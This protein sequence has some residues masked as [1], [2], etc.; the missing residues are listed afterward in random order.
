MSF[1]SLD[2][3][4]F[5]A[6]VLAGLALM[7]TRHARHVFLLIASLVFYAFGTPWFVVVLL[8][9]SIVDYACAI[10]MEES[11]DPAVRR[12]WLVLSLVTNLGVLCY[13]KYSNF[14]IDDFVRL[15]GGHPG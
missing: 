8:V 7:P 6:A 9:P 4:V 14:L 10:R 1:V 12:Q 13:F 5:L 15:L 3:V 2:F 11:D